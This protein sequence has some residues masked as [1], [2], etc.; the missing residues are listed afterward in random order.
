MVRKVDAWVSEVLAT[1]QSYAG[2]DTPLL[3]MG[4]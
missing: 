4:M 3:L 2:D 1:G